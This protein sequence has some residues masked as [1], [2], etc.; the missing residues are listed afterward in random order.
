MDDG[1]NHTKQAIH[2]LYGNHDRSSRNPN[3]R[4]KR[5]DKINNKRTCH[6]KVLKEPTNIL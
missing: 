1:T 5:K 3:H 6:D 4:T 2:S